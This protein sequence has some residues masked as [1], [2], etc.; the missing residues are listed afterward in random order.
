LQEKKNLRG[1]K[2]NAVEGN[3]KH[4]GRYLPLW[5]RALGNIFKKEKRKE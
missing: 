1:R 4:Q 2:R 5:Q 3:A